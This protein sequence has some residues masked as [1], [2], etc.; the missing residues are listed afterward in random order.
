MPAAVAGPV[1][2]PSAPATEEKTEFDVFLKDA[3]SQKL[4]VIKTIREITNL[5]LKEAKDFV[6]KLD[7]PV[8]EKVSKTEAEEIKKK[9]ESVGAVVEI[10]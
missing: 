7:K 10:K 8:K 4:Q 9:L 1:G 3:G 5:G 2:T 6:E